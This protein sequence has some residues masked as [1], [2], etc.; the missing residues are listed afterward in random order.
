MKLTPDPL[1]MYFWSVL[2]SLGAILSLVGWLR[3][4]RLD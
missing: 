4:L 2:A 1:N 3:F